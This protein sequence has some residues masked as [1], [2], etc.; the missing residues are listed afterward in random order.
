MEDASDASDASD[1]MDVES[2]VGSPSIPE[3]VPVDDVQFPD[4]LPE[5][6][7]FTSP[8]GRGLKSELRTLATSR[9]AGDLEA[10]FK[11]L[12]G[13]KSRF[14]DDPAAMRAIFQSYINNPYMDKSYDV[15]IFDDPVGR[16]TLE[17]NKDL[18]SN[19]VCM[20]PDF[21]WALPTLKDDP[22]VVMCYLYALSGESNR[23]RYYQSGWSECIMPFMLDKRFVSEY[24]C[25]PRIRFYAPMA[26]SYSDWIQIYIKKMMRDT[27]ICID[28]LYVVF[29]DLFDKVFNV[30][31]TSSKHEQVFSRILRD[32]ASLTVAQGHKFSGERVA[33]LYKALYGFLHEWVVS[34]T[35][36]AKDLHT[37]LSALRDEQP[38]SQSV[39]DAIRMAVLGKILESRPSQWPECLAECTNESEVRTLMNG[40]VDP[41]STNTEVGYAHLFELPSRRKEQ[42]QMAQHESADMLASFLK[43][44]DRTYEPH[45]LESFASW[46]AGATAVTAKKFLDRFTAFTRSPSRYQFTHLK[47][48]AVKSEA[49][50]RYFPFSWV[51]SEDTVRALINTDPRV[52]IA[53]LDKAEETQGPMINEELAISDDTPG[54]D[55]CILLSA[56]AARTSSALPTYPMP[57]RMFLNESVIKLPPTDIKFEDERMFCYVIAAYCDDVEFCKR[58]ILTGYYSTSPWSRLST[59]PRPLYATLMNDVEFLKQAVEAFRDVAP[60]LPEAIRTRDDILQIALDTH[61]EGILLGYPE[62]DARVLLRKEGILER[63]LSSDPTVVWATKHLLALDRVRVENVSF[64]LTLLKDERLSPKVR[65]EF[66][67]TVMPTVIKN[68]RECRITAGQLFGPEIFGRGTDS[69]WFEDR[70]TNTLLRVS[71]DAHCLEATA[72]R[73]QNASYLRSLLVDLKA[74]FYPL[75]LLGP[76]AEMATGAPTKTYSSTLGDWAP[77]WRVDDA[78]DFSRATPDA[79]FTHPVSSPHPLGAAGVHQQLVE[80]RT[81]LENISALIGAVIEPR[82]RHANRYFSSTEYPADCYCEKFE[83]VYVKF[84]IN[85]TCITDEG[86]EERSVNE[87]QLV[88]MS[89]HKE[90]NVP[91]TWKQQLKDAF[92]AGKLPPFWGILH[93]GYGQRSKATKLKNGT[94]KDDADWEGVCIKVYQTYK[95]AIDSFQPDRSIDVDEG[96]AF[97]PYL[98]Q[99]PPSFVHIVEPTRFENRSVGEET[100]KAI[101]DVHKESLRKWGLGVVFRDEQYPAKL[102]PLDPY[103]CTMYCQKIA[104]FLNTYPL[105]FLGLYFH[106]YEILNMDHGDYEEQTDATRNYPDIAKLLRQFAAIVKPTNPKKRASSSELKKKNKTA[107]T[108]TTAPVPPVTAAAAAAASY[109][110]DSDDVSEVSDGDV[111]E[112]SDGDVS[113]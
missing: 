95:P 94:L 26:S 54:E 4:P 3:L 84:T 113:D 1:V 103:G 20:F 110:Y 102:I 75:G 49:F 24:L 104:E 19:A 99:E 96:D 93:A 17:A 81:F 58:F 31:A 107:K 69:F 68:D 61:G 72:T 32:V 97:L 45:I 34:F 57:L 89:G 92:D 79:P 48:Q 78:I 63:V 111:S 23:P 6:W 46:G 85:T 82:R 62:S 11:G 80:M 88:T 14:K 22:Q 40:F 9:R 67:N 56:H 66:Y 90:V 74:R 76:V 28:E 53:F 77:L 59:I 13:P 39:G 41:E 12:F 105:Q 16:T 108:A 65:E 55:R 83:G 87:P 10:R 8:L 109:D 27:T 25:I 51:D 42:A 50:L 38:A 98:P 52:G 106:E 64:C 70:L 15:T 101:L 73:S 35:Y 36:S 30:C 21:F 37:V 43:Y 71:H 91:D 2:S 7:T 33:P 86:G 5:S 60:R 18:V 47:L 112:V 100:E 44:A 29:D